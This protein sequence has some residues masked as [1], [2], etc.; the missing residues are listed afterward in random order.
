MKLASCFLNSTMTVKGWCISG[1]LASSL[2]FECLYWVRKFN[3]YLHAV[4]VLSPPHLLY[5]MEAFKV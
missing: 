1:V 5:A 3:V 2:S 4:C